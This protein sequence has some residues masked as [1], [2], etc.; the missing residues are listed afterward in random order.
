M[1]AKS[2][3]EALAEDKLMKDELGVL[4]DLVIPFLANDINKDIWEPLLTLYGNNI[5]PE[6]RKYDLL[7][8]ECPIVV[9][10]MFYYDKTWQTSTLVVYYLAI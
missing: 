5:D 7:F 9:A 2:M 3:E 1:T 4:Y 6:A 10:G 8:G